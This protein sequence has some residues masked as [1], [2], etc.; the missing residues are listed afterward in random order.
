MEI[1]G[2]SEV[3]NHSFPGAKGHVSKG[4]S[5]MVDWR[6]RDDFTSTRMS[7]RIDLTWYLM[8]STLAVSVAPWCR[9]GRG[10]ALSH[11]LT[12]YL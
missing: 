11:H 4:T 2:I 10:Y 7:R 9:E 1:S 8:G 12:P 5:L 6:R 3:S